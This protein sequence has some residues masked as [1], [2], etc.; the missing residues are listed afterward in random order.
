MINASQLYKLK[1]L[2]AALGRKYGTLC[3]LCN[4]SVSSHKAKSAKVGHG[5]KLHI[6]STSLVSQGLGILSVN[7]GDMGLIPGP[8]R[9]H[10]PGNNEARAQLLS[11]CPR[12]WG[13]QLLKPVC[14]RA[15]ALQQEGTSMRN[16]HPAA[17][18]QPL[19]TTTASSP[20]TAMKTQC[21]QIY[22]YFKFT[23]LS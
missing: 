2:E 4:A 17:G 13:P 10:M 1:S 6:S 11:Q 8:D 19:L 20:H 14:P 7:A 3:Y 5:S 18:E 23:T 15:H 22:M 12:A 9:F 21:S 16:P